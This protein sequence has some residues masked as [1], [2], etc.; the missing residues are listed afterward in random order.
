[1]AP[2]LACSRHLIGTPASLLDR[3]QSGGIFRYA[4]PREATSACSFSR[5][6]V[7]PASK[8]PTM[9]LVI[10]VNPDTFDCSVIL[11]LP[12][13]SSKVTTLWPSRMRTPLSS[14]DVVNTI[15]PGGVI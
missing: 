6:W 13:T 8:P 10:S 9:N 11:V 14:T 15:R 4:A 7:Q 1:M 12:P 2:D 5:L 3:G